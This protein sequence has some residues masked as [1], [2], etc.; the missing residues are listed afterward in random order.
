MHFEKVIVCQLVCA[1]K[2]TEGK[3]SKKRIEFKILRYTQFMMSN[4][5]V[6]GDLEHEQ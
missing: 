5:I 6:K 4:V 2:T 3:T 1:L